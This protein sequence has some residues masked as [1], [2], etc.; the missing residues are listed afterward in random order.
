[1]PWEQFASS[2]DTCPGFCGK[3]RLPALDNASTSTDLLSED[4]RLYS[5]CGACPWGTKAV[6]SLYCEP[7]TE[8]LRPYDFAFIVF[9]ALFPLLIN[10]IVIKSS[11]IVGRNLK[12]PRIW[13][14]AQI[15]CGFLE[16]TLSVVLVLF[17]YEPFG[18]LTIHSCQNHE[19]YQ[20]YSMWYN[21][22]INYTRTLRC[23][24]EIVYPLYSLPF[25]ILFMNL[26]TLAILRS[27]LYV[28]ASYFA[29]PKLP[30][31]P[32]Y[33][34]MW[35]LPIITIFHAAFSGFIYYAFP[36]VLLAMSLSLN[37]FHFASVGRKT[38]VGFLKTMV[39][40]P[41]HFIT[42]TLHLVLFGFALYS[43]MLSMPGFEHAIPK[44]GALVLI[45]G[46]L[47]LPSAYYVLGIRLTVPESRGVQR[48]RF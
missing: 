26:V 40:D 6:N 13:I 30:S 34:V 36:Y 31:K 3:V 32:F 2:S 14:V 18:T 23:T 39:Q 19:L 25:A 10:V 28:F 45:L 4:G 42:Y 33:G 29:T 24:S 46:L 48:F 35:T 21:P 17:I 12:I 16:S 7:C 1:M 44:T 38:I 43:V 9:H 47:P 27:L 8:G 15:L 37:V 11:A 41:E 5:D 22:V 20:W